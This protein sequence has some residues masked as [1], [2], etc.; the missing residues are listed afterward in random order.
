MQQT[1]A[2]QLEELTRL[3]HETPA[4]VI[5]EAVQLGLSRLYVETVLSQYLK[6]HMSRRKTIQLVG[7]EAVVLAEQ[8]HHATQHD[9]AWGLSRA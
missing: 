9:I 3:R 5:A 1:M 8:Q 4:T 6:K 7:L 2:A